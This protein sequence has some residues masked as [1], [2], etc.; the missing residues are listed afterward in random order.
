MSDVLAGANQGSYT[1]WLVT[2]DKQKIV[3]SIATRVVAYPQCKAFAIEFVGGAEMKHWID[4][5][6]ETFEE[7][8]KYNGCRHFEAYGRRAWTKYLEKRNFKNAYIT[9]EKELTDG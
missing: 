8:A 5:A 7:I 1:V 4:M 9:F 6:L 3:A 2:K